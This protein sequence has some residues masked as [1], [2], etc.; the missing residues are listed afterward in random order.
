[1]HEKLRN[2]RENWGKIIDRG[3]GILFIHVEPSDDN[4]TAK[5][6][7]D[8]LMKK[9]AEP[10]QLSNQIGEIKGITEIKL[11]ASKTDIDY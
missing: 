3:P 9:D 10:I 11:I 4:L 8:I 5:L 2:G 6:T 7:F 1:M